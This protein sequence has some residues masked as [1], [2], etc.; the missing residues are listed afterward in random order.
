MFDVQAIVKLIVDEPTDGVTITS[1]SPANTD[2][3]WPFGDIWS[4]WTSNETLYVSPT[5]KIFWLNTPG[6]S[7]EP[8]NNADPPKLELQ[9]QTYENGVTSQPSKLL[10]NVGLSIRFPKQNVGVSVGV[11]VGVFVGALVD[12]NVGVFV[13]VSVGVNVGVFVGVNVG[14]FVGVGVFVSV[15]VGVFVGVSVG[16]GVF[17][18]VNVGVFV[19]VF[20]GVNVGVFVGVSVGVFVGVKVGV[21]VGVSVGVFVRVNVGVFVGVWVCVGVGVVV[22]E[23]GHGFKIWQKLTSGWLFSK[24]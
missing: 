3:I 4:Y 7:L 10:L 17:V 2:I 18:S 21:F 13:G 24:I 19:G 12:V 14:V 16:V 1:V 6:S 15:N 11:N 23:G 9:D 5:V 8:V 22:V 20:V